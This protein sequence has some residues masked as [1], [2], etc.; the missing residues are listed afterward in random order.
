MFRVYIIFRYFILIIILINIMS[1]PIEIC[2]IDKTK[3]LC[4]IGLMKGCDETQIINYIN[5]FTITIDWDKLY[6]VG[7]N[8]C[9]V[10]VKMGHINDFIKNLDN[11]PFDFILITGDGDETNPYSLL[12]IDLFFNIINNKKIIKW[13]STNCYENLHPKFSLIPI[14]INYHCGALW[15][16]TP[17]ISQENMIENIR[18]N[19]LPFNK[20]KC[21]CYSNFHFVLHNNFDNPRKKAI[22]QIKD[23][24]IYYEPIKISTEQ[25]WINQ[26]EYSFVVSPLGNGMDCHRTWEALILGCIVIVQTSTLDTLYKDLPVLI[27]NHWSDITEKLLIDTIKKFENVEFLYDKLTLK[28]WIDEIYSLQ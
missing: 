14:G 8:G 7:K 19:A 26:S 6:K 5:P 23:T 24:L 13:Y 21:M 22:E 25:T 18:L 9:C 11:I 4:S 15:Y 10:Y 16:N 17:I 27:V 12:N 2:N 20:R 3:Y 28:Y 1:F